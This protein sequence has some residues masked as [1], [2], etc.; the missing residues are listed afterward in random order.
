[1]NL[2]EVM[3]KL[4][5]LGSEQTRKIY[6]R[7]GSGPNLFGV[8]FGD[9]KQIAKKIKTNHQLALD[10]WKTNNTD[11]QSLATMIADP[12]KLTAKDA[13]SW[14]QN[15]YYMN[16]SLV[17]G[18]ISRSPSAISLMKKWMA[19]PRE[20]Y[21]QAGYNILSDILKR[22][23]EE[24]TE[25]ISDQESHQILQ[26]IEQEIHTSA[27]RAR[28]A[29]NNSL[30]A[31]AVYRPKLTNMAIESAKRIGKVNVD[32]G[33]TSCKTPEAIPYIKKCLEHQK[34]KQK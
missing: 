32:H 20:Y 3:S 16:I 34:K 33:K 7:H 28:H 9:L 19:D 4:K 22:D 30:I 14:I 12:S 25:T 15:K 31:I 24:K 2:S 5:V 23:Y 13:E 26:T 18:V 6:Q 29:M 27:N 1:M 8:K 17:A 21:R 10:L 11:A